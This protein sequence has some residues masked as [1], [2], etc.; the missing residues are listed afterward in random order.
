MS[1]LLRGGYTLG[2]SLVGFLQAILIRIS[3]PG[4]LVPV[5]GLGCCQVRALLRAGKM[6]RLQTRTHAQFLGPSKAL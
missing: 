3:T 4:A 2:Q 1:A 6:G 5:V